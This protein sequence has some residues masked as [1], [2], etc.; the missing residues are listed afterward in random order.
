MKR[1]SLDPAN[2]L[3]LRCLAFDAKL[4]STCASLELIAYIESFNIFESMK[5]G[6][7]CVVGS[8][9]HAEAN[10]KHLEDHDDKKRVKL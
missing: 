2:Y 3:A 8:K 1:D 7:L 10:D 4:F 9:R 6:G 5:R